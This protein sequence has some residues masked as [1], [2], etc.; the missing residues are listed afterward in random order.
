MGLLV[1][2][3]G[4][5]SPWSDFCVNSL[6]SVLVLIIVYEDPLRHLFTSCP[7]SRL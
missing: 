3:L 1:V 2:N 4:D 5:E 6:C 7:R